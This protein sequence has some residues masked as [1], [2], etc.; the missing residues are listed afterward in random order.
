MPSTATLTVVLDCPEAATVMEPSNMR[1]SSAQAA[2]ESTLREASMWDDAVFEEIDS[3]QWS[4]TVDSRHVIR[5]LTFE[6]EDGTWDWVELT[7]C[8]R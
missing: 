4:G 2:A 7:Y 5:F 1:S 8:E 6:N 3:N